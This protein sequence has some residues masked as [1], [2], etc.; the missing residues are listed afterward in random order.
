MLDQ[1]INCITMS[2]SLLV[3]LERF[4]VETRVDGN[5][6]NL[7]S[8]IVVQLLDVIANTSTVGFDGGKNQKI[9]QVLI[10]TERR[11]FKDNLLEQFDQFI[12]QVSIQERL[13][14][15]G[16][17]IGISRFRDRSSGD[18]RLDSR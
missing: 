7:R 4:L 12:R 2:L 13:D 18:L 8:I 3:D 15:D 6:S 17:I 1:D 11:G 16:D 9:L 5:G 14:R 10:L